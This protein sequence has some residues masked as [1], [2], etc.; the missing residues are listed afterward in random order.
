MAAASSPPDRLWKT[1]LDRQAWASLPSR[2]ALEPP[3]QKAPGVE[4]VLFTRLRAPEFDLK[5]HLVRL[6][7]FAAPSALCPAPGA[8]PCRAVRRFCGQPA[9]KNCFTS[10]FSEDRFVQHVVRSPRV[11]LPG[12]C[13][14]RSE[15][16]RQIAS[17]RSPIERKHRVPDSGNTCY[18]SAA[19]EAPAIPHRGAM[20]L[21]GLAILLTVS[22]RTPSSVHRDFPP[23]PHLGRMTKLHRR[24]SPDV[25][26]HARVPPRRQSK[27]VL[28]AHR[29]EGW[30]DQS[31]DAGPC[32]ERFGS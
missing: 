3:R 19:G 12:R 5:P 30:R 28:R 11:W 18:T 14:M 10:L 20:R 17:S 13:Q 16:G 29:E 32:Q 21:I 1:V 7:W 9:A 15:A 26:V 27:A 4:R 31:S 24:S 6:H 2:G 22:L 8:D 25:A 23:A